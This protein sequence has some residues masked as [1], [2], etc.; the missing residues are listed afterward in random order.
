[1]LKSAFLIHVGCYCDVL[2]LFCVQIL[3]SDGGNYCACVNAATLA[4]I[5]AGIP[6]KDY[7]CAC[8]AGFVSD[9]PLM[10]I[11]NLEE[12]IGGPEMIVALLP[13]SQQIVLFQMNSRLH[14]DNLEQVLELATKGAKD[15]Y[16]VLDRVVR[17]HVS[18]VCSSIERS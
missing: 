12:S 9:T 6:M 2:C 1:M 4:L 13:K 7:V 14:V 18:E 3:Q 10:D 11:S 16:A 15:V 17:D 8:S 5:D